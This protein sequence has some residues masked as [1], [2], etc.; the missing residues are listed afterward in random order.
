MGQ[1]GG[2]SRCLACGRARRVRPRAC[3]CDRASSAA[4]PCANLLCLPRRH[5][6][7]VSD[8]RVDARN[9]GAGFRSVESRLPL[10]PAHQRSVAASPGVGA[11]GLRLQGALPLYLA[12]YEKMGGAGRSAGTGRR[13]PGELG[14]CHRPS[15]RGRAQ[16]QARDSSDRGERTL[17]PRRQ[18]RRALVAVVPRPRADA[19]SDAGGLRR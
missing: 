4:R 13:R 14:L 17:C 6:R 11:W 12:W 19:A 3:A 18:R 2:T 5:R 1:C 10:Q 15:R 7:A 16:Q 8:L 9:V